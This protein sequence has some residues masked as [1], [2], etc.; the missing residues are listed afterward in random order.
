MAD[1]TQNAVMVF[2]SALKKLNPRECDPQLVM[3]LL[4]CA[5]SVDVEI[6]HR[7]VDWLMPTMGFVSAQA[8]IDNAIDFI[9]RLL[10]YF[11]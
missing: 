7:I 8:A 11:N 10:Y 5:F 4:R 9:T 1:D 3:D 6:Y 2:A